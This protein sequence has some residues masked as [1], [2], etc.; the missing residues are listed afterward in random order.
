MDQKKGLGCANEKTIWRQGD[1]LCQQYNMFYTTSYSFEDTDSCLLTSDTIEGPFYLPNSIVRKDIR[2]NQPGA[3]LHLKLKLVDVRGCRPISNAA[4]DI[5]QAN[6]F[7]VYSGYEGI[8]LPPL[9][10]LEAIPHLDPV[11]ELTFLRGR[12]F[13]DKNGMA[14]FYTIYPGWYELRTVHIHLK[15]FNDAKELLTTQLFFPQDLTYKIQSV[16]PY[17]VR[18]LSPYIN[19]DDSVLRDSHGVEGGWPRIT[20]CGGSYKGTL[21]IGVLM[22]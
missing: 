2:E 10:A 15:L 5:W 7:G 21:T 11:N 18:P 20:E 6:A 13:T 8:E 16:A 4:I 9:G 12:Q 3:D 22:G 14:E 17:N 1:T 19:R